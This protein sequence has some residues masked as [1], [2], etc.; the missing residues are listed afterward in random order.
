MNLKVLSVVLTS[1]KQVFSGLI[2][3]CQDDAN[4]NL[5]YVTLIGGII[6]ILKQWSRIL[7]HIFAFLL[8]FLV[9]ISYN[10]WLLIFRQLKQSYRRHFP[11]IVSK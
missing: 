4:V 11:E 9:C 10:I 7:F 2:D 8:D 1:L 3:C 6:M 5:V